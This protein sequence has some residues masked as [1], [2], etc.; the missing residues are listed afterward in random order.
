MTVNHKA[1]VVDES[2]KMTAEKML[3]TQR[4]Q[5]PP[6]TEIIIIMTYL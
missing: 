4:N 1:L 6:P 3:R 5:L 2:K